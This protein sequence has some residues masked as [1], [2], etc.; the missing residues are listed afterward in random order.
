MSTDNN[1]IF[2]AAPVATAPD[3][4]AP[5]EGIRLSGRWATGENQLQI[6]R[7]VRDAVTNET[8][9]KSYFREDNIFKGAIRLAQKEM[10]IDDVNHDAFEPFIHHCISETPFVLIGDTGYLTTPEISERERQ[11]LALAGEEMDTHLLPVQVVS[12]AIDRKRAP[13]LSGAGIEDALMRDL[14]NLLDAELPIIWGTTRL[15]NGIDHIRGIDP[16]MVRDQFEK[17]FWPYFHQIEQNLGTFPGGESLRDITVALSGLIRSGKGL[18]DGDVM[19]AIE[20]LEKGLA[21]VHD[22][23]ME[24]TKIAIDSLSPR[25][26][27]GAGMSA[28]QSQGVINHLRAY[29]PGTNEIFLNDR[30]LSEIKGIIDR[31]RVG[32]GISDEQERAA[33]A[34]T[35]SPRRVTVIEGTAGAGKSYTMEVVKDAYMAMGY[36]VM[37]TALSWNAAKVLESSA[38]LDNSVAT[39]GLVQQMLEAR[40]NGTKFFRKPTLLI[41]DEAGMLG[42]RHMFHL[43][44][45]TR[46]S[47]K[48]V[49]VVLT[50]DSLQ[51]SPVDAGNALQA[52]V[53]FHGTTRINAIRRQKQESHRQAVYSFSERMA[54]QGLYTYL[55]QEAVSWCKDKHSQIDMVV[56]DYI[57]Y[58]HA[59][60]GK[61]ALVLALSNHDV[62]QINDRIRQAQKKAGLVETREIKVKVTDGREVW[63]AGFSVGD[64]V[65]M[66]GND[67]NMIV[68]EIDPTKSLVDES[69]WQQTRIG[70]FNRNAGVIRSITRSKKVPGSYDIVVDLH[71]ERPG[72]VVLNTQKFRHSSRP[73]FPVNHNFAT[74][75]YASQGQTVNQVFL[76]D[77]AKIDFRLAYVGMSRHKEGVQVYL[78]ENELHERMNAMR[79]ESV[80]LQEQSKRNQ[81]GESH[82]MNLKLGQ[83]KRSEMIQTVARAWSKNSMNLT[84]MMFE[85]DRRGVVQ[86]AP[87]PP[88]EELSRIAPKFSDESLVTDFDEETSRPYPLIDMKKLLSLPDPIEEA[89]LINPTAVEKN[90]LAHQGTEMELETGIPNRRR[91]NTSLPTL[92]KGGAEGLFSGVTSKVK[93]WWNGGE[94]QAAMPLPPSDDNTPPSPFE[95]EEAERQMEESTLKKFARLALRSKV[96]MPFLP[97]AKLMGQVS[98]DMFTFENTP[99]T[100]GSD[101]P[102]D[103]F[104]ATIKGRFWALGK[105]GEPRILARNGQGQVVARY[106]LDGKCVVGEGFPPMMLNPRMDKNTPIMIVPGAK[107]WLLTQ[108]RMNERHTADPEKIPH[109]IWAARESD[110]GWVVQSMR[111]TGKP[112]IIARSRTDE[113]QLDW[114]LG[115]QK[116]LEANGISTEIRPKPPE[117]EPTG[118]AR[119]VR[120]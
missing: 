111:A 70:A 89:D 109:L 28:P 54:G 82:E 10:P 31:R 110:L 72:R 66:R 27:G 1:N 105:W 93:G 40:A 29:R 9:G 104:L 45:E 91:Q 73:A 113:G 69:E 85:R 96:E 8:R 60:P 17:R 51:L 53:A 63:D 102:P 39:E 88:A 99:Q 65:V 78:N 23:A 116:K 64:E 97:D 118:H 92:N 3:L 44:E 21:E 84:A 74:T 67:K 101:N 62:R 112:V 42:T 87:E 15:R 119:K 94:A 106:R 38:G 25:E 81:T 41:V 13:I 34:A 86:K 18:T 20:G 14:F 4:F 2:G 7:I 77:N 55:H 11:M 12:E 58:R 6:Q 22:N 68:Y 33:L 46:N 26:S 120:P 19:A 50:G 114:A 47:E 83:Y 79:G 95:I 32:P 75:I 61:S 36:Q 37:G 76:I 115:L 80:P 24:R 98:G 59:F 103:S 57:S 35:R 5:L 48:P 108:A 30:E 16:M 49:K 71:G 52:I 117:I 56:R 43:L 107:E 100:P 90:N